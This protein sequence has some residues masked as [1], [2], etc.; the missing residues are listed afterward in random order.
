M[1]LLSFIK[2]YNFLYGIFSALFV[3]VAFSSISSAQ[4]T[5]NPI[6]EPIEKSKLSIGLEEVVKIPDSG[7]E[8]EISARLNRL[9]P[10]GDG[11]RRLFVNDMR[12]NL[13]VIINDT[14]T[15][16]MDVKR[17]VGKGFHNDSESGQ[18]GFSYFV[19]HPE[20]AKN[21]IFYTVTSEDKD[22]GTPDFPVTKPIFNNKGQRRESSH[23]DVIREWK[24]TDSSAN[25]FSGTMREILRIEQPYPDHNT[26]QLG[27][28]P[29]AKPGD[30]DYGMLYIAEADGGSD[31]FPVSHT[32]PLDN[33]QDLGTPLGKIL[34]IDP[35]GNNSNN[36]KYGIPAD[37]PFVDDSGAGRDSVLRNPKTLGEIWAYGLRN[38][39]RFSW[40]T[41]GEGKML[42]VDTGQAFIEEVNLGKKG[43]NYG[44][45]EREGTWVVDQN[46]EN[47]L[48]QLPENDRNFHYAYPVAQYGHDIPPG[49]KGYYGIAIAGGFV[50]R[51]TAIP[52]LVG[53][54]VFAD[55]GSDGRFFHVPVDELVEG[56]QAKIKELRL[57]D[58]KK[59]RSFLEIVGKK[60][61]DVRFGIDEAEELYVTSKQDGKVRK[62]VP[63]LES[64][65]DR[66]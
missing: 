27:F 25:T 13:Y 5:K 29:N 9:I 31:G 58:G 2:K 40:D 14:A 48:Y 55:F 59:E 6:S 53:Q 10:A 49:V 34:R 11:R 17:L 35:L 61:T 37:N 1:K 54:Y 28:N 63:S 50:Y 22:T 65:A 15:V 24:A 39:H 21:G 42:I 19:F 62:I 44:W 23:H 45:G 43:A 4:I 16:Y 7:S 26:G 18:Q 38:P 66:K 51:G 3:I 52:E 41:G 46:N 36:G 8:D 32:D 47:V 12:G 33:G 64:R 57:F 60:R 56:K 30:A 20:F